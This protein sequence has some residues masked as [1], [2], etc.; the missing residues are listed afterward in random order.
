MCR[1]CTWR[2]HLLPVVITTLFTSVFYPARISWF[3]A[4]SLTTCGP[5]RSL[6]TVLP[7]TSLLPEEGAHC[8]PPSIRLVSSRSGAAGEDCVGL[9]SFP[10]SDY[11]GL[12]SGER[13]PPQLGP[14]PLPPLPP[15]PLLPL[16]LTSSLSS[17]FRSPPP[18]VRAIIVFPHFFPRNLVTCPRSACMTSALC[19]CET[20]QSC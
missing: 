15:P 2:Q 9:G 4:T 13:E 10:C 16:L 19:E 18:L 11:P 6:F 20:K 14:S 1:S 3:M 12:L 7:F 8:A 17:S 5:L